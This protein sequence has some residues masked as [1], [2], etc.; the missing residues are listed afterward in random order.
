MYWPLAL[1]SVSDLLVASRS[2]CPGSTAAAAAALPYQSPTGLPVSRAALVLLQVA[3][4][5]VLLGLQLLLFS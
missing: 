3:L 1:L 4:L 2:W 5:L